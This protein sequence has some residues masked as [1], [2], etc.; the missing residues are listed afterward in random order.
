MKQIPA[1]LQPKRG[2]N[3]NHTVKI[4]PARIE[5]NNNP[6]S[7]NGNKEKTSARILTSTRGQTT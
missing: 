4:T 3:E 6:R 1:L 7:F 5:N 2:V